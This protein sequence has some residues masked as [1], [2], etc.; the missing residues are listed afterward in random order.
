MISQALRYITP[1]VG[2]F[3]E[4]QVAR[5]GA[6]MFSCGFFA[7]GPVIVLV[8]LPERFRVPEEEISLAEINEH[9]RQKVGVQPNI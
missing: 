2:R 6:A 5:L 9:L 1:R 3:T 8:D 7:I 4:T